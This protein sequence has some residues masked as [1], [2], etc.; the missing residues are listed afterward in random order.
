MQAAVKYSAENDTLSGKLCTFVV[1]NNHYNSENTYFNRNNAGLLSR[2]YSLNSDCLATKSEGARSFCIHITKLSVLCQTILKAV[3]Q[4][5]IVPAL[6]PYSNGKRFTT[7]NSTRR[8]FP[9]IPNST[10]SLS[11]ANTGIRLSATVCA[12]AS[13]T[14][15]PNVIRIWRSGGR[16]L[17]SW[18]RRRSRA[19]ITSLSPS[20]WRS[21]SRSELPKKLI[22]KPV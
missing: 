18:K 16:L 13:P 17:L 14:Y 10:K 1:P 2:G 20:R 8:S 11:T 12:S 5:T 21:E 15:F 19:C 22:N 9:T 6:H 7:A 3:Q 4:R